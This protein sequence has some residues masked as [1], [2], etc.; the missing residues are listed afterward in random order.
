MPDSSHSRPT[1]RRQFFRQLVAGGLT[2]GFLAN[3]AWAAPGNQMTHRVQR[4]DTLSEIATAYG[5]SIRDLKRINGLKGDLIRIGQVLKVPNTRATDV[6]APVIAATKATRVDRYRW[7]YIVAHH[8]AIENGNAEIYGR[9]HTR[10]GMRHGLAY[11]FVIGNGI[12]SGDGE[13]E[14]GPR[15]H[16]QLRGGHVRSSHVNDVGIGICMVGNF[17]NHRP[18]DRQHASFL[19][20]VDYL[21]EGQVSPDCKFT[22]HKWVDRAH[23]LCPGKHF[24]YDEMKQRYM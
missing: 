15:W 22:V 12:D 20:L 6:L 11:H 23:T 19:Q 9:E 7:R 4:G 5:V 3:Q 17:E 8:S 1:S 14:I 10:R 2:A 21:R 13:I 18:T 24:P 16:K